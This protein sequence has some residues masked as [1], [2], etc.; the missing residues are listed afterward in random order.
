MTDNDLSVLENEQEE[1]LEELE[2]IIKVLALLETKAKEI[3]PVKEFPRNYDRKEKNNKI[4]AHKKRLKKIYR[5]L[6]ENCDR[7]DLINKGI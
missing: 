2:T 4:N 1:L 3:H 7:I 5:R 6:L